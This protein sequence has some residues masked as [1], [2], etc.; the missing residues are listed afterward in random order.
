MESN[1][2][3]SIASLGATVATGKSV[4]LVEKELDSVLAGLQ[5]AGPTAAELAR[6]KRRI[7]VDVLSNL[8]LL[9]GPGGESGRAGL[10]QRFDQY[11]GDPGYLPKWLR[12][13]EEVEA[14]DVQRVIKDTLRADARVVVVTEPIAAPAAA[15]EAP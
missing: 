15:K 14:A 13:I 3:S 8:E 7:L 11:T 1:Q 5:K 6:A 9:N 2:L 4:A 10:L 12:Q